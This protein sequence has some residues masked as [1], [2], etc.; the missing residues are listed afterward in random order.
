MLSRQYLNWV[1]F[2]FRRSPEVSLS[3]SPSPPPPP[4][5]ADEYQF[6]D[7]GSDEEEERVMDETERQALQEAEDERL[8][9]EILEQEKQKIAL[10]RVQKLCLLN[11]LFDYVV[12]EDTLSISICTYMYRYTWIPE[13]RT[14]Q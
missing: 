6:P 12:S 11:S 7:G 5:P 13:T 10:V 9:R 14:L 3:R 8:A 2:F 1:L 4:Y